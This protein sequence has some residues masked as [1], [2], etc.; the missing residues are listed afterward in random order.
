MRSIGEVVLLARL[1]D[2]AGELVAPT[3]VCTVEFS[4]RRLS[5]YAPD[6]G[7]KVADKDCT[8]LNV[9]EVICE[10]LRKDNLWAADDVGYNFCHRI[11]LGDSEGIITV[12]GMKYEIC[13]FLTLTSGD[14]AVV[15]FQLRM[16]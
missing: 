15:C 11:R 3:D 13:Y 4:I 6:G 12:A 8:A 14:A 1:V 2:R 9:D 10:A 5:R 7:G 16:I